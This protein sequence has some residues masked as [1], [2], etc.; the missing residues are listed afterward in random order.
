M[1]PTGLPSSNAG[2]PCGVI[3]EGPEQPLLEPAGVFHPDHDVVNWPLEHAGRSEIIGRPDLAKVHMHRV[4]AFRA[5]GAEP[6]PHRLTH[7]K[8]E[9][10]DPGHRQIGQ[11]VIGLA[12]VI[13][14]GGGFRRLDDVAVL[15]TTPFGRPVGCRRYRASRRCCRN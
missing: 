10:A 13:E 1:K 3:H 6:G 12:Q 14:L 4:R 15:S 11:D 2:Q 5:F 7:G 9:I 8:D